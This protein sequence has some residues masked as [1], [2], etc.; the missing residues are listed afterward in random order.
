VNGVAVPGK[1]DDET[2]ERIVDAELVKAQEALASGVSPDKV[3][4]YMSQKNVRAAMSAGP[5]E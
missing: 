3:Y 1:R 5:T 4:V 2:F